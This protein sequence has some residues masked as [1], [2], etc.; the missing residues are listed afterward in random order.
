VITGSLARR[1]AKA[2][3]EIGIAQ[4]TYD[5]LGKEL[6]RA[7]DTLRSSP[8]L[9]VALENPV[10]SLEKRKLIMDELSRRLALSRTVRNFIMLLLDKGRI[11][12]LPD[13]ARV[14]RTLIDEHAG[15][16]RATVPSARP[17]DPLLE[18]RLKTAL[19][20]SSGKVVLFD[21]REDPAILG[22]L[23][24]QLGDTVYDGSVRTQLQQLRDELLSE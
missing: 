19:E 7:A 23:V 4:Q 12:A 24:T 2:L 22:G 15:R 10:F 8:E 21:K 17:L 5:A 11:A 3:L 1:Y 18:S 16:M 20:K 13:I 14:H 6:D 9:R